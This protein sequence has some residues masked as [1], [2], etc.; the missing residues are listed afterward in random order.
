M[1]DAV[2]PYD[3]GDPFA[4][5]F[6][7]AAERGNSATNIDQ[8]NG[9]RAW[10][11]G[12]HV[13]V[14][15]DGAQYFPEVLR[16]LRSTVSGDWVYLTD[17]QS[18]GDEQLDGPGSEIGAVLSDAAQRGVAV[19]G[20]L[21]RSHPVGHGAAEVTNMLLSRT[22]NEAG[23]EVVLDHRVRRKGSHHQ[24]LVV[25]HRGS[26]GTADHDV[27]FLGG[28]DLAHGR[29]DGPPHHGD[30]Q[31]LHLS[32]ARY[33][34]H[35][36]WHDVQ[37]RIEGPAVRQ[38]SWTFRERW[39]DPNPLDRPTPA[40]ALRHAFSRKPPERGELAELDRSPSPHGT[41]AVQVLRTYPARR[42]PY[43]F[44]PAG[45]RSIARAYMK[46][47]A[48]AREFIY[49]EDQYL[50]S[51]DATDALCAA[52]RASPDLRCVVVI[53]RYPDPSGVLGAAS[54]FG[55]WRVERA[56]THA[57][58]DRVAIYD[59][60]NDEGTPIYVHAKVCIVDDTWMTVGSDNLNRRSWT[61]DSEIC[62]AVMDRAGDLPSET[63]VRLAREHL[64]L[65]SDS[66]GTLRD[67][68]KWFAA[69]RDAATALDE[70]HARGR[71]GPRP[72]GRLRVHPRDRVGV[73][74]RPFLHRLHSRL[75]DPDGRP[76]HL[77]KR[78]RY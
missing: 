75:L 71:T 13:T 4:E 26:Q 8:R 47:F 74:A 14:L 38:V 1:T 50:W 25:I 34:D 18:D 23:G 55:R 54:R 44:A 51:L 36:P 22:V 29:H 17:L 39:L 72:R 65:D 59:L 31:P 78:G 24:K 77:R 73:A 15:I 40:R 64:D 2:D 53:P 62:C 67:H 3:D 69:L 42:P 48:K 70:W 33:S 30:P 46:A 52:L 32:D 9:G 76:R 21:W 41:H 28:I 27:A 35:P 37:L 10:T 19:R 6:L 63:R 45:E 11:D 58:G 16:E 60:E 57:G 20:L 5:W 49:V 66:D 68:E 43:P 7:D 12:N 61:H 56:L